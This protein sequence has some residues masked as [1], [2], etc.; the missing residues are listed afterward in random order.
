MTKKIVTAVVVFLVVLG[1]LSRFIPHP[2]NFTPIT[3]LALFGA[4]YLSKRMA[5]LIPLLAMLASDFFIGFYDWAI[6]LSVYLSFALTVVLGFYLKKSKLRACFLGAVL[7]SILFFILT[8]FA[9]W[10]FTPWYPKTLLGFYDC[11]FQAL[12]FFKNTLSGNLIYSLAFFGLFEIAAHFVFKER[13][14]IA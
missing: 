5:F 7:G 14:V 9:V 1:A 12:P 11:Y 3:A 10:A 4:V 6:W 2:P 13:K 8:N